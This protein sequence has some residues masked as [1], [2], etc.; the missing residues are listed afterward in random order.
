MKCKD[1]REVQCNR[2]TANYITELYNVNTTVGDI[3]FCLLFVFFARNAR[4]EVKKRLL[5][6][7]VDLV[8]SVSIIYRN[9][10]CTKQRILSVELNNYESREMD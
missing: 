3:N 2:A 1:D 10:L 6:V 4:E 8:K 9:C 5:L 7:C